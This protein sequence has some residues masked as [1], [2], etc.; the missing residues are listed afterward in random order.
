MWCIYTNKKKSTNYQLVSGRNSRAVE[1][2]VLS[3][4]QT[5]II[6]YSLGKFE[7]TFIS[8]VA[9]RLEYNAKMRNSLS[10][11][12]ICSY[13]SKGKVTIYGCRLSDSFCVKI[14]WRICL[15][16][17]S[18]YF[19]D[20]SLMIFRHFFLQMFIF[21][22]RQNRTQFLKVYVQTSEN[23]FVSISILLNVV[24]RSIKWSGIFRWLKASC[25]KPER[26]LIAA[27]VFSSGVPSDSS[28]TLTIF[29]DV[30]KAKEYRIGAINS[31]R[32]QVK[33]K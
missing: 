21:N 25:S 12:H 27:T 2:Q 5:F 6:C 31:I 7:I 17:K 24:I 9:G 18:V 13:D 8:L 11:F 26:L 14:R 16:F 28:V 1:L 32:L 23:S 19:L 22:I 4:R 10:T 29:N 15:N 20:S 33:S 3:D 30:I